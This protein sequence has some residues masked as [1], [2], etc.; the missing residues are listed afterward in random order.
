MIIKSMLTLAYG[1]VKQ[2]YASVYTA[3]WHTY[4]NIFFLSFSK[5]G[6]RQKYT[7]AHGME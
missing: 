4:K 2:G 5:K 3:F 7:K 1:L 6:E